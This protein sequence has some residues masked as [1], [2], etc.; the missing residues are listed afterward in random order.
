MSCCQ[1]F[2]GSVHLHLVD[3]G[4]RHQLGQLGLQGLDF[5]PLLCGAS[6]K[7]AFDLDE[8]PPTLAFEPESVDD[9]T[10]SRPTLATAVDR[11]LCSEWFSV[12]GLRFELGLRFRR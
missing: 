7:V 6:E 11:V 9:L 8:L 10:H 5:L 4:L 3:F 1:A 2:E 12:G